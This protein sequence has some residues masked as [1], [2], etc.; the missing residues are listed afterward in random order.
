TRA[1][2][3]KPSASMAVA[4]A[5]KRGDKWLPVTTKRSTSAGSA[6]IV[7]ISG[8]NR[9]YSARLPVTTQMVRTFGSGVMSSSARTRAGKRICAAPADQIYDQRP[10]FPNGLLAAPQPSL[11]HALTVVIVLSSKYAVNGCVPLKSIT[12][13]T[14]VGCG[15]PPTRS[16]VNAHVIARGN[17]AFVSKRD[18]SIIRLT[19]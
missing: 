10:Y 16:V 2:M 7:F 6:S 4:V 9:P 5:P 13:T 17:A 14:E 19:F 12:P 8:S 1:S 15:S 11:L 18:L 3:T